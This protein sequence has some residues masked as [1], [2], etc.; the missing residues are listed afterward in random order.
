LLQSLAE[1][2]HRIAGRFINLD[3]VELSHRDSWHFALQN[4]PESHSQVFGAGELAFEERH[5]KVEVFV[6]YLV[7]DV[8][9]DE[10]AEPVSGSGWPFT[11][12]II[13]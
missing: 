12:T 11:V 7:G 1:V 4:L 8:R 13:S 2:F 3:A 5:I 10:V 9:A 6:V